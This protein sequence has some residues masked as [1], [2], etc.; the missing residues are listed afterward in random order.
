[1]K[2]ALLVLGLACWFTAAAQQGKNSASI[3]IFYSS[4]MKETKYLNIL[5]PGVGAEFTYEPRLSNRSGIL[6]QAAFATYQAKEEW[7]YH[8]K[9][10]IS[11]ASFKAAYRFYLA[12]AGFYLH[13]GPGLD[14]YTDYE[15]MLFALTGGVGKRFALNERYFI[16]GGVDYVDGSTEKRIHFKVAIGKFRKASKYAPVK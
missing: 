15:P 5:Q 14:Y 4:P 16:D 2:I 9:N 12:P 11:I 13:A 1:M 3:G 10:K 7:L 6:L 8:E